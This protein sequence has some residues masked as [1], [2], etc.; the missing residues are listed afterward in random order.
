[1]PEELVSLFCMARMCRAQLL[2]LALLVPHSTT[3]VSAP[4]LY[5]PPCHR[6]SAMRGGSAQRCSDP[7]KASAYWH[8]LAI[9]PSMPACR[10]SAM[11]GENAQR[12]SVESVP[13]AAAAWQQR[14]RTQRRS[15]SLSIA[16]LRIR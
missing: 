6:Q 13:P 4:A 10:Q 7:T 15:G 11:R 3:A 16:N 2:L 8:A 14:C 5:V 12:R 1:M 9:C